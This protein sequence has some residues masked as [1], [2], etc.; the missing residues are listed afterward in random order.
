M[1]KSLTLIFLTCLIYTYAI[2]TDYFF[3]ATEDHLYENPANWIPA[4]PGTEIAKGD[5]VV[6]LDDVNFVGF[7]IQVNGKLEIGMGVSVISGENGFVVNENGTIDN[8]GEIL[9]SHIENYGK[10]YNCIAARIYLKTFRAFRGAFTYNAHS[11]L[12]AT[13]SDLENQ[14]RF[15]NYGECKTG[16]DFLNHAIFYQ[17]RYAN[18]DVRGNMILAPGSVFTH[19]PQS[20]VVAGKPKKPL[21]QER[22][23]DKF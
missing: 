20:T 9:V 7:D 4:Y 17:V 15:D 16:N 8:W 12:F 19:S 22:L 6:L 10:V 14:G 11:S 18:L 3:R 13:I 5:R 21:F 23:W 1:R 2:G